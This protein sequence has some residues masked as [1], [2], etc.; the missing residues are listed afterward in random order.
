[1][2]GAQDTPAPVHGASLAGASVLVTGAYGLIGSW[3]SAALLDL[4]ARVTVLRRGARPESALVLDGAE[5]G[6][7]VVD[8]DLRD[9]WALAQIL[10]AGSIDTLFHL[11]AQAIVGT[12]EQAP[13]P[14]FEAN[15]AGTWT[16]LEAS[17]IDVAAAQPSAF[18]RELAD[19]RRVHEDA[20]ALH[21]CDESDDARRE[22][23]GA[24]QQH[25]VVDLA[26]CCA[27]GGD[28]RKAQDARDVERAAGHGETIPVCV[29]CQSGPARIQWGRCPSRSVTDSRIPS[30]CPVSFSNCMCAVPLASTSTREIDAYEMSI[31]G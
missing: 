1:M 16:L 15:V 20:T 27:V 9:E 8:G 31:R 5:G 2:A 25:D 13:R 28:Q 21:D 26:D 24:G 19:A 29:R 23:H 7:T 6:C 30:M 10:S 12:A 14:T 18:R 11:A 17:D 22:H 3:L 4:G